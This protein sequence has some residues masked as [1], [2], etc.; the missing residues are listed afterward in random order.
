MKREFV[1]CIQSAQL[2]GQHFG[3]FCIVSLAGSGGTG[4]TDEVIVKITA[5]SGRNL[6]LLTLRSHETGCE[7]V[8]KRLNL[9]RAS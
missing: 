3:F 5:N 2:V 4:C 6:H 9:I 8:I 7:H 1:V